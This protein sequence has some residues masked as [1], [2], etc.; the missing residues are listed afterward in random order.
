ML[1]VPNLMP[2]KLAKTLLSLMQDSVL[3]EYIGKQKITELS[4]DTVACSSSCMAAPTQHA[5][6]QCN[7]Q[8]ILHSQSGTFSILV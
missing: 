1:P 4:A 2:L 3:D 7:M 8:H 6:S 5:S